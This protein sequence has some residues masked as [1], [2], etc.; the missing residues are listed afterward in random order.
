MTV[1]SSFD[2]ASQTQT[3]RLRLAAEDRS[4]GHGASASH[5]NLGINGL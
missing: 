5:G 2:P 4:S 1:A 3:R